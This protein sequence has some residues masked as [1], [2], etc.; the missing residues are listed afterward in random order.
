MITRFIWCL[1][2]QTEPADD[3][4]K[5]PA[6]EVAEEGERRLPQYGQY[7]TLSEMRAPH[8][9]IITFRSFSGSFYAYH[10]RSVYN[11]QGVEW[12]SAFLLFVS[13]QEDLVWLD[14]F[15]KGV[16]HTGRCQQ[17]DGLAQRLFKV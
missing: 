15:T 12:D 17:V 8:W 6:G 11:C 4:L 10:R 3:I 13:I 16:I 2:C 9:Q 14:L 1:L 7:S 5:G